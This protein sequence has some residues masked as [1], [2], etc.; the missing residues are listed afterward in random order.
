MFVVVIILMGQSSRVPVGTCANTVRESG[1]CAHGYG[2]STP[3][4]TP[5]D[6]DDQESGGGAAQQTGG[7]EVIKDETQLPELGSAFEF[8]GLFKGNSFN[9]DR[10]IDNNTDNS[11]QALAHA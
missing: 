8:D 7:V 9:F 5:T 4:Y 11:L 2:T 10:S 6:Q 1:H 3:P